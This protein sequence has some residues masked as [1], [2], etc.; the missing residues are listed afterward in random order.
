[1]R[2]SDYSRVLR[3]GV[4]VMAI[5]LLLLLFGAFA[6]VAMAQTWPNCGWYQNCTFGCTANDVRITNA[7]LGYC[8]NGTPIEPCTAGTPVQA[9]IWANYESGPSRY[10]IYT[11]FDLYIDGVYQYSDC[12]CNDTNPLGGVMIYG[13]LQW[14]CGQR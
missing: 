1:M 3:R 5:L 9:C 2:E 12:K 11:L 14:I 6:P 13:P 8:N 4:A 7:W 10:Q